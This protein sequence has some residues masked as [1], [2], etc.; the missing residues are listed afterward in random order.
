MVHLSR[1][2]TRTGDDGS[3]AL[4]DGTR[5]AKHDLRIA[6][7]GTVDDLVDGDLLAFAERAGS[8]TLVARLIPRFFRVVTDGVEGAL[9][10]SAFVRI[11]FQA[12]GADAS[13]NPDERNLLQDW[14]GDISKFNE[15]EDGALQFFR[16]QVEFDL[17]ARAAGLTVDTEPV[18]LDFL[19]IPFRF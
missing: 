10:D 18:Q 14:T 19:R 13:G 9:P 1:I 5:R 2:Y 6:A 7:Y 17:D 15:L 11:R 16:F 3:T 12:T 8:S 4:G